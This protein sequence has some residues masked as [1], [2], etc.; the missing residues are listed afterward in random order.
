MTDTATVTATMSRYVHAITRMLVNKHV[1]KPGLAI[2]AGQ[3]LNPA[4]VAR[5]ATLAHQSG[6]NIIH[7]DFKIEGNAATLRDIV[8][9]APRD[10][11][12]FV[13]TGCRLAQLPGQSTAVILPRAAARGHFRILPNEIVHKSSKPEKLVVEGVTFAARR[14]DKLVRDDVRVSGQ[15]DLREVL[16]T[17]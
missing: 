6:T 2:T 8:I 3:I 5:I 11:E 12:C 9:A 7:L 10:N 14:L 15:I 13:Y 17:A 4:G 1:L 16:Q